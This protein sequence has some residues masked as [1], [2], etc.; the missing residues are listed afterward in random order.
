MRF[1]GST[2]IDEVLDAMEYAVYVYDVVHIL[3]D[4]LQFMLSSQMANASGF[5]R[6]EAQEQALEKFRRFGKQKKKMKVLFLF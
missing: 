4:N 5:Q 1:Y 3:L 2:E 6:F